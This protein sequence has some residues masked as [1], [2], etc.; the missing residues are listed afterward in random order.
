MSV[1]WIS[2]EMG[3]SP[4][5]PMIHQCSSHVSAKQMST[6]EPRGHARWR[7]CWPPPHQCASQCRLS[8]DSKAPQLSNFKVKVCINHNGFIRFIISKIGDYNKNPGS[9]NSKKV[10]IVSIVSFKPPHSGVLLISMYLKI[11]DTPN[12]SPLLFGTKPSNLTLLETECMDAPIICADRQPQGM[13][14]GHIYW[15]ELGAGQLGFAA[16]Q[17]PSTGGGDF[18]WNFRTG[19]TIHT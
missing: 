14:P 4:Q 15:G 10:C 1:M 18:G 6:M 16:W 7:P 13:L 5:W 9:N 11:E 8:S 19:A 2:P 3:T 17:S 12:F